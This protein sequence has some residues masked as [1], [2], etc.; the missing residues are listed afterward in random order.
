MEHFFEQAIREWTLTLEGI[1]IDED[2]LRGTSIDGKTLR[3]SLQKH[4]RAVHLLSALDHQTGY[5]LSQ[6]RVDVKTNEAKAVFKLFKTLVLKGKVIIGDAMFCQR[7]I[8]QEIVNSD[9]DYFFVVK[10]NQ[11]TLLKNIQLAFT[12]TEGFSPLP[13]MPSKSRA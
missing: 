8:C 2:S 1:E 11:P 12:E 3:G 13:T 9:G 4:Q 5:V 6:T 10:E 7:D